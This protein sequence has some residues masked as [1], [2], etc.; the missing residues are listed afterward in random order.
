MTHEASNGNQIAEGI[1]F[2]DV[3]GP[4]RNSRIKGVF[5]CDV[6]YLCDTGVNQDYVCKQGGREW[7][8]ITP[9]GVLVRKG[10]AWNYCTASPDWQKAASGVHDL[11]Y[12]FAGCAWFP[13]PIT[14]KKADSIFSQFSIGWSAKLFWLGLSAFS[15]VCWAS[16]PTAGEIVE[17][18]HV[19]DAT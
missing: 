9:R 2:L 3:T 1:H 12:Q 19:V 15:W 13:S 18:L 14:R 17:I 5:L 16:R 10:Y 8:R 4:D 6:L 7:G 11:L